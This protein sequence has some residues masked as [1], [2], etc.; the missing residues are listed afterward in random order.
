MYFRSI[1][2]KN[3]IFKYFNSAPPSGR[4][5]KGI[6]NCLPPGQLL[7][8]PKGSWSTAGLSRTHTLHKDT[9]SLYS[10]INVTSFII[11]IYAQIKLTISPTAAANRSASAI[12]LNF[13]LAS[14]HIGS[15]TD[16]PDGISVKES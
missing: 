6:A 2:A 15:L 8:V 13:L 16:F 4:I 12:K 3:S 1:A 11:S 14:L 9:L 7:R 5:L 10:L